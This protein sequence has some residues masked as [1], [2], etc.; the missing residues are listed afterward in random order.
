MNKK[1]GE[2]GK[3]WNSHVQKLTWSHKVEDAYKFLVCFESYFVLKDLGTQH[4]NVFFM[5]KTFYDYALI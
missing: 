2:G 1:V 3:N 4:Q 5:T